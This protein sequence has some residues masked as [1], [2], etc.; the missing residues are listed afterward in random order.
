MRDDCEEERR[1]GGS[2]GRGGGHPEPPAELTFIAKSEQTDGA[3]FAL[4]SIAP[5]GEGRPFTSTPARRK[6]STSSLGTFAGRSAAHPAMPRR[7]RSLSSRAG[8]PTPGRTSAT[9]LAR[10][11]SPSPPP[12]WRASSSASRERVNSISRSSGWPGRSTASR[13]SGRRW[14]G[15]TR[16]ELLRGLLPIRG[17]VAVAMHDLPLAVLAAVDVRHPH[18]DRLDG[19]SADGARKALEAD[20]VGHAPARLRHLDVVAEVAHVR[21]VEATRRKVLLSSSHPDW[22]IP[23]APNRVT[24]SRLDQSSMRGSRS[25]CTIASSASVWRARNSRKSSRSLIAPAAS[26]AP[27]R[28]RPGDAG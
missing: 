5:P 26:L 12:E 14:P 9:S 22:F 6:P 11:S 25:P 18:G 27:G 19:P 10:C 8:L 4:E 7:A 20:R 16:S 23:A 3:M 2:G 21:E 15:P 24:G 13:R 17:V 1:T 28:L